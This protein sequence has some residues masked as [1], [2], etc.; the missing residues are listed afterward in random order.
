MAKSKIYELM[1]KI[2]GKADSSL[3]TACAVADKNLSS[4][5]T[6]AKNVGKVA[7]GATL[8]AAATVGTAGVAAVKA[9]AGY[10]SQ[11]SNV[12]TLLDGTSATVAARTSEIGDQILDVSNR[13]KIVTSDLTDGMYQVISAYGDSADSIGIL[14]T[15]SKAAK[16]GN[17]TT[18]DSINL[19]SAVTKGYGDIS[20]AANQKVADMAFQ[21]VKLGQTTFPELAASMGSV[22]GAASTLGISQEELFGGF[23]TLTGVTGNTAEVSTQLSKLYEQMMDPTDAMSKAIQNAGYESAAAMVQSKGLGSVLDTLM[24]SVD[25]D[26]IAF[27]N[28]F[29]NVNAAKAA[30]ALAGAQADNY[31]SKCAEMY[32]STGAANTAFE[33]QTDNLN[34]DIQAIKTLGENFLIQI[35]QKVLPYVRE[36]AEKAL[37][38]LEKK[39]PV[40]VDY[41]TN[42]AIP[43][44]IRAGSW[45]KEHKTLLLSLAGGVVALFTAFKTLKTINTVVTTFTS[46]KS[47]ISKTSAAG[48]MLSKIMGLGGV[49]MA[50]IAGAIAVVAGG[51]IYLWNNSEKF[52]KTVIAIWEK[53]KPLGASLAGL[54]ET[55]WNNLAPALEFV[56]TVLVNGLG[57]AVQVLAPVIENIIGIFTGL[58][59][60]ITGVFS[61]DWGKAW[62]G[63]CDIFKNLFGGLV[64]IA[65]IP[66]NAV[67][68]AI[69]AVIGAINKCG[70]T[71]PKWVPFLGG[72][73]FT[74]SLP[75]IPMLATGGIATAPTM[76]MIGEG[77]EPEAVLPL[78]KLAALLNKQG[79]KP[80]PTGGGGNAADHD[81]IMW[82]P[83]FNFYG[84]TSK[85]EA[86]E[87]G[88]ISFTEFKRLY[89]QMKAEERRKSFNPA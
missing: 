2:G 85:E 30:T 20:A 7:A 65:K 50:L 87:V 10:E 8:A 45:I 15:A 19:L 67:I 52:R 39:I 74:I 4:L 31:A 6:T 25:G 63:I 88:R 70:I 41:I 53:L 33:R 38:V 34:D 43:A 57:N 82:S 73:K 3:K 72:K 24:D 81:T 61:G 76:A 23:S 28:M 86:K 46:L 47:I 54:A 66:I 29:G 9:A 83:V 18:T 55:A 5:G 77:A 59:D 75:E 89:K 69:D 14:E 44:A 51:F 79:K 49:K 56:G 37:P 48:G 35:G 16:A 17:T 26:S 36:L 13:T 80:K 11:L 22:T 78:S 71:I 21:T 64:N 42:K 58:I 84:P 12:S 62:G 68:G 1:L 60:F 40:I 32:K 27:Y